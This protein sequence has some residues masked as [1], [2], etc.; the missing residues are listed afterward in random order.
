[1]LRLFILLLFLTGLH[2]QKLQ[3]NALIHEKSPYLRMH[4]H[5]DGFMPRFI[6]V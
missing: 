6:D 2:A 5:K 3:T 4:A 1:V